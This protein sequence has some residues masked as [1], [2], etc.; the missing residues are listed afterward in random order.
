MRPHGSHLLVDQPVY[1]YPS[2]RLERCSKKHL[3]L[4][5]WIAGLWEVSALTRRRKNSIKNRPTELAVV[6]MV[7]VQITKKDR[8]RI[9]GEYYLWTKT[10]HQRYQPPPKLYRIFKLTVQI[11]KLNHVIDSEHPSGL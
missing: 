6:A 3:K 11:G 9:S 7:I 8:S 2:V 5:N 4:L 10:S 1:T